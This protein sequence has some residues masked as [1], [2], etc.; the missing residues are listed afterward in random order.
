M[1]VLTPDRD[2]NKLTPEMK[3]R[4]EKFL[5]D[6]AD[7]EVPVFVTEGFRTSA[8]QKWLYS[9]GRYG[10]NK[11]KGVLTW[12]LES[13]HMTGEAVDIAFDKAGNIYKGDWEKV[14]D[15]AEKNGLR[16]LF[17]DSG[18]DK[19]H[20]NFDHEWTPPFNRRI[21]EESLINEG[22]VTTKKNIDLPPTREEFYKI[23]WLLFEKN[24]KRISKIEEENKTLKRKIT[25]I[26]NIQKRIS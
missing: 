14:F 5:K 8:R 2:L 16:S 6:C 11:D 1:S 18:F 19:P 15:I 3:K 22:V 21:H 7:A 17:R 20:L 26:E 10:E 25:R 13:N 9:F 23:A 4:L 24:E 12:T